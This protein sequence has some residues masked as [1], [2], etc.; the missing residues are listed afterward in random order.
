[1]A[2]TLGA[3]FLFSLTSSLIYIFNDIFDAEQDKLHPVKKMRPIAS[4]AVSKKFAWIIFSILL[5]GI[6]I[7]AAFFNLKFQLILLSYALLNF[8]YSIGLKRIVVVDILCIASGFMFRILGGAFVID[9]YISSWLILTTLFVSIFLAS[10]KRKSELANFSGDK[11]TRHVL[12]EYSDEFINQISAI[13]AAGVIICYALYTVS[14]RTIQF[15]KTE[16]LVFTTIFV[17]FGIFRYIYLS[18]KRKK[19]E[20]A[21]EDIFTDL[22]TLANAFLY[23]ITIVIIIY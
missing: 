10:M 4:G 2:E 13:T 22:P 7:F 20:N 15:F 21:L 16:N 19:G 8:F 3:F 17:I 14:D 9:V 23:F 12:K 5:A 11:I 18:Y 6:L 1:M